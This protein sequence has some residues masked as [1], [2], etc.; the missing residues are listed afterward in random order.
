MGINNGQYSRPNHIKNSILSF[1]WTNAK[2][3]DK[4]AFATLG[5]TIDEKAYK[6]ADL[7]EDFLNRGGGD[8]NNRIADMFYSPDSKLSFG[9]KVGKKVDAFTKYANYVQGKV[10]ARTENWARFA[11]YLNCLDD[12]MT[13]DQAMEFVAKVFYD[14]TDVSRFEQQHAKR[15]VPFYS[16]WRKNLL[17]NT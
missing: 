14:Y 4:R 8:L 7:W 1:L 17:F 15:W 16:F 5:K 13:P 2:W 9:K 10:A 12:G 11:T 6:I 3:H